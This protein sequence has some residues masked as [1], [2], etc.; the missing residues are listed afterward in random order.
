[1]KPGLSDREARFVMQTYRRAEVEFVR[2]EG[3][4]L[5]D[6][7]GR[8]YLDFLSGIAVT[9]LGHAHPELLDAAA[10]QAER[11]GHVSNLFYSEPMIDLAER[12]SVGSLGGPV[13]FTNSGTEANECAIKVARKHAHE[14]GVSEPEIITF[15]GGFHGRTYGS[16][17]ASPK[18]AGEVALGPMLP[19]F[20]TV[21]FDDAAG[22]E[23]A[24]SDRTAAVMLE[25]IQGEAG[26]FPFSDDTLVT[27][28]DLADRFGAL[29]VV[30][31]VQTGVG[32]TGSLWGFQQT[33]VRPD[34]ITTAKALGGGFPIGACVASE[35]LGQVLSPGDHG[36]T[37]AGGPVAA[38]VSSRV[39]DLVDRPEM[40]RWVREAGQQ[41]SEGLLSVDGIESVRGRG[42]MVGAQL[43]SGFVAEQVQADLLSRGLVTNAP[44]PDTL[45]LL[46]PYTVTSGQIGRA[47]ELIA[48]AL[49]GEGR[50]GSSG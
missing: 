38:A 27:A 50:Q 12:L 45:R 25:T 17:S 8:E 7:D 5:F 37:F 2:G 43:R 1:L 3:A 6:D 11:L 10:T 33:P 46:P 20:R 31:E 29:L 39:L 40:L 13:F 36:S 23:A 16:L 14:R 4:L 30:D 44:R 35:S 28:R 41:L 26:V 48:A 47:C 9:A 34:L 22:L 21:A 18:M 42:L 24:F 19:G 32:R 49:G 15:E